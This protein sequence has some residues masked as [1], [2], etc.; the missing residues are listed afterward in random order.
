MLL[1]LK[2]STSSRELH[3]TSYLS[4]FSIP[5]CVPLLLTTY[6]YG[7]QDR[8]RRYSQSEVNDRLIEVLRRHDNS[9]FE[10]NIP[11]A[12]RD[13]LILIGLARSEG[14]RR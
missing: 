10:A 14:T 2:Y 4:G 7:S 11:S 13:L 6:T 9:E 8:A 12:V 1:S 5:F 3:L